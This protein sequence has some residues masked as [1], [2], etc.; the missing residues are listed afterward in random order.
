MWR[1]TKAFWLGYVTTVFFFLFFS[2]DA[3]WSPC[4]FKTSPNNKTLYFISH[5][6]YKQI[7]FTD[8]WSNQ[9]TYYSLSYWAVP[10]ILPCGLFK[11]SLDIIDTHLPYG[12]LCRRLCTSP[13]CINITWCALHK[14]YS[15]SYLPSCTMYPSIHTILQL[16]CVAVLHSHAMLLHCTVSWS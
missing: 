14:L 9:Q 1:E 4:S 2:S 16:R 11:K 3:L 13:T 5:M 6:V 10:C 8:A 15:I 12:S 7:S